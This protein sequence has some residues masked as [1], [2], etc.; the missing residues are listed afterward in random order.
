MFADYCSNGMMTYRS[1]VVWFLLS[2]VH[3]CFTWPAQINNNFAKSQ[4][5]DRSAVENKIDIK[6]RYKD[7]FFKK[8]TRHES[9][10]KGTEKWQ[11]GE[12]EMEELKKHWLNLLGLQ[13]EPVDRTSPVRVPPFMKAVYSV[14]GSDGTEMQQTRPSRTSED[15]DRTIRALLP[16]RGMYFI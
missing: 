3:Q 5:F 16:Q 12:D 8:E 14:Y 11:D 9:T 7:N 10:A 13:Q 2:A 15:E 1:F 6:D 4:N